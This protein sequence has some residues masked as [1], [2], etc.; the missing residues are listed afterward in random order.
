[1]NTEGDEKPEDKRGRSKEKQTSRAI[2]DKPPTPSEGGERKRK[3]YDPKEH[4]KKPKPIKKLKMTTIT[5]TKTS[6]SPSKP[7]S[8]SSHKDSEKTKESKNDYKTN[9]NQT[10][11]Q[12]QS[13]ESMDD[14][15]PVESKEI[16]KQR[17]VKLD[18]IE[19]K[20]V[21]G[22]KQTRETLKN[23]LKRRND[24]K[25]KEKEEMAKV[26]ELNNQTNIEAHKSEIEE[27]R[28]QRTKTPILNLPETACDLCSNTENDQNKVEIITHKRRHLSTRQDRL[29]TELNNEGLHYCKRCKKKHNSIFK[30]RR[31]VIANSSLETIETIAIKGTDKHFDLVIIEEATVKETLHATKAEYKGSTTPCDFLIVAPGIHDLDNGVDTESIIEDIKTLTE[32]ITSWNTDNT[33]G[34]GSLP[35]S[36]RLSKIKYPQVQDINKRRVGDTHNPEQERSMDIKRINVVISE[37]NNR[38]NQSGLNTRRAP[39]MSNMGLTF[40]DRQS[41]V[42]A[43]TYER[44]KKNIVP[45]PPEQNS[46]KRMPALKNAVEHNYIDWS[47]RASENYDALSLN[48]KLKNRYYEHIPAYFNSLTRNTGSDSDTEVEDIRDIFTPNLSLHPQDTNKGTRHQSGSSGHGTMRT[49]SRQSEME[50]EIAPKTTTKEDTTK[51]ET[52]LLLL[53]TNKRTRHQSESS[54][55][56]TMRTESRQSETEA[57]HAPKIT[58]LE[59]TTKEDTPL[60]QPQE[61]LETA[62]NDKATTEQETEPQLSGN[63]ETAEPEIEQQ[64]LAKPGTGEQDIDPQTAGRQA[65]HNKSQNQEEVLS[66]GGNTAKEMTTEDSVKMKRKT[67]KKTTKRSSSSSTSSSSSEKSTSSDSSSASS[68]SSPS[69]SSSSSSA[70]SKKIK[71]VLHKYRDRKQG[72]VKILKD[73]KQLHKGTNNKIL[74]RKIRAMKVKTRSKRVKRLGKKVKALY[75]KEQGKLQPTVRLEPIKDNHQPP[76]RQVVIRENEIT[77]ERINI[78]TRSDSMGTGMSTG[79]LMSADTRIISTGKEEV[80]SKTRVVEEHVFEDED[81]FF[82]YMDEDTKRD[83]QNRSSPDL[84]RDI[85]RLDQEILEYEGTQ[86]ITSTPRL[87]EERLSPRPESTSRNS[88]TTGWVRSQEYGRRGR[89]EEKEDRR[90]IKERLN[91]RSRDTEYDRNE[92]DD[93]YYNRYSKREKENY[94][95]RRRN[96]HNREIFTEEKSTTSRHTSRSRRTNYDGIPHYYRNQSQQLLH[97]QRQYQDRKA[98]R[99]SISPIRYPLTTTSSTSRRYNEHTRNEYYDR[100][101]SKRSTSKHRQSYT[102]DR[103]DSHKENIEYFTDPDLEYEYQYNRRHEDENRHEVDYT[104]AQRTN[105]CGETEDEEEDN[106]SK[107]G[108]YKEVDRYE[109]ADDDDEDRY[110]VKERYEDNN[111]DESPTT[112]TKDEKCDE[113]SKSNISRH[114]RDCRNTTTPIKPP[115]PSTSKTTTT[116]RSYSTARLTVKI[117]CPHCGAI[118]SKRNMARHVN[119]QHPQTP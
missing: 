61:Q 117:E 31:V 54:G 29:K 49:E 26:K 80:T 24:L 107:K 95:E 93:D 36:P 87:N 102:P 51:K 66:K 81:D 88:R 103:Y 67:P 86:L 92:T 83:M 108:R 65:K 74:R 37:I 89:D 39:G 114:K 78:R 82:E 18:T 33:I 14:P 111:E 25:K 69:S 62:K 76:V 52:P 75:N 17:K 3:I 23:E 7:T 5:G 6:Y 35:Y 96:D 8:D 22:K 53:Q 46:R 45:I 79:E 57:E 113:S 4:A 56:G 42:P 100:Y 32:S 64:T 13:S 27:R 20:V 30:R 9:K 15:A 97:L 116:S 99:R 12:K 34:I 41:Y 119:T 2:R 73:V 16:E 105:Y 91:F 28:G 118:L 101:D 90:N 60:L 109:E 72:L 58:T 77:P 48:S 115:T 68:S 110:E 104:P 85:H 106:Y 21:K 1:M 59:D 55:H 40:K 11:R 44:I 71:K 94:T 10:S 112:K 43:S 47:T 70:E 50:A 38:P 63:Q 84:R 19:K 98:D